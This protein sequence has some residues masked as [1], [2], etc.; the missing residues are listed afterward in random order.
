MAL[1]ELMTPL[2]AA[3][4]AGVSTPELV[5]AAAQVGGLGFLAGGYQQV[6]SLAA[7]IAVVRRASDRRF[8]VNLLLP[9]QESAFVA[10]SAGP[11]PEE[12]QEAVTAYRQTL[13]PDAEYWGV[14]LP[15]PDWSATDQWEEKVELLVAERV[16]LVSFTFGIPKAGVLQRFHEAGSAVMITVTD[17]EEAIQGAAAGAD[18]LIV[19]GSAAGGH[20]GTMDPVKVPADRP[21]LE[22]IGEVRAAVGLPLYAAGGLA[23][24]DAVA[25]VIAAGAVA[26]VVGTALLRTPEAATS[27]AHRGIL[28]AKVP[29]PIATS[30]VFSGRLGRL[31]VN[32]FVSRHLGAPPAFP[33][34]NQLTTPIRQAATA[35]G[36]PAYIPLWAG[37][38][39][40]SARNAPAVEVLRILAGIDPE[41]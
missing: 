22:L 29:A 4:M 40:R 33:V 7:Q 13:L 20:R 30:R 17:L 27:P 23:T 31:I 9:I 2:V 24:P 39:W 6:D 35:A 38:G 8:G 26:A 12:L 1:P 14:E 15:E 10:Q 34:V 32:D 5:L 37:E 19:Q 25:E 3:P 16:P 21:L 18:G 36:D 28:A 11:S 41:Y